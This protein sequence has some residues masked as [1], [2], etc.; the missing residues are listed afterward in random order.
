MKNKLYNGIRNGQKKPIGGLCLCNWGGLVVYDILYGLDDQIISAF[1]YGDGVKDIRTT[2][3]FYTITG[4][5]YFVRYKR[6]YY[7]DNIE[8]F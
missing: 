2:K 7:L 1:D 8:R 3:I 4:R 5:P 6:R